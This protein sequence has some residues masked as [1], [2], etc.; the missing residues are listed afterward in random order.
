MPQGSIQ[1]LVVADYAPEWDFTSGGGKLLISGSFEGLPG[2]LF[3]LLD[4]ARVSAP[5]TPCF[6]S[7]SGIAFQTICLGC[8]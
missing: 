1:E 6:R 7:I 3:V 8:I 4:G 2:P 5:A